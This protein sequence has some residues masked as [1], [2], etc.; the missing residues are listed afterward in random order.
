MGIGRI[1]EVDT[2]WYNAALFAVTLLF[3][4]GIFYF[5]IKLTRPH[6]KYSTGK[7]VYIEDRR[8]KRRVLPITSW[9]VMLMI[10]VTFALVML[11]VNKYQY[12]MVT[13]FA[14]E[15]GWAGDSR[16]TDFKEIRRETIETSDKVESPIHLDLYDQAFDPETGY[17]GEDGIETYK[18]YVNEVFS[19]FPE[20][21][22]MTI[23][24]EEDEAFKQALDNFMGLVGTDYENVAPEILWEGYNDG[25][26][27]IEKY[28][29]SE[30]IFQDGVLAESAHANQYTMF[31]G[32]VETIRY[33][34]GAIVQFEDFLQ[35]VERYIGGGKY[36]DEKDVSFRI[37]KMMHREADND[38]QDNKTKA[39][40]AVYA[41]SCFRYCEENA[42]ADDPQ[43]LTFLY[44]SGVSCL[45]MMKYIDDTSLKEKLC[46]EEWKKWD[47]LESLRG[48]NF[49]SF[50]NVEGK[51]EEDILTVKEYLELYI[52]D[53]DSSE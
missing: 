11:V 40:C 52:K 14:E 15:L 51:K 8:R 20:K 34:D 29:T 48:K 32:G 26:V 12:R 25:E 6:G 28:V 53:K 42:D 2:L 50:Y 1:I 23:Y 44:Y 17:I 36:A 3:F 9:Q 39:H 27:V 37:G 43:Y 24:G 4:S 22:D 38:S 13:K 45:D 19:V 49:C 47:E 7:I 5:V 16:E 46:D 35:Y 18:N 33:L 31:R 41:Y 21:E 10:I 30:N